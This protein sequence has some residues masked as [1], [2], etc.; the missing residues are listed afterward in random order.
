MHKNGLLN[1]IDAIMSHYCG[2]FKKFL[3]TFA[4]EKQQITSII[5]AVKHFVKI[6]GNFCS[7][8]FVLGN[9]EIYG[10]EPR[11]SETSSL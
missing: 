3:A 9:L 2:I 7:P 11:Y 6:V 4:L 10:K 8:K 5:D 1:V